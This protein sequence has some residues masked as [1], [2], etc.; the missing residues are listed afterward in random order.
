MLLCIANVLNSSEIDDIVDISAS[1]DNESIDVRK[2]R[3]KSGCFEVNMPSINCL[4]ASEGI[5]KIASDGYWLFLAFLHPGYH[6]LRSSGSCMSGK[7]NIGCTYELM[8]EKQQK[9]Q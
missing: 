7:I 2:Y 4:G 9:V 6:V 3:I 5:T 1:I 8:V